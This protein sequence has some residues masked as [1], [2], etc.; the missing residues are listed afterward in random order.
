M[1]GRPARVDSPKSHLASTF[2][3]TVATSSIRST[4]RDRQQFKDGCAAHWT[5]VQSANGPFSKKSWDHG[6]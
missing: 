4:I 1:D 2:P 6:H 5:N 3:K